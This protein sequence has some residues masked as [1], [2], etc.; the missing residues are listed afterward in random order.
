MV[1]IRRTHDRIPRETGGRIYGGH[2]A[3]ILHA[4]WRR[5]VR[6]KDVAPSAAAPCAAPASRSRQTAR[7][8]GKERRSRETPYRASARI[9]RRTERVGQF[10]SAERARGLADADVARATRTGTKRRHRGG[11]HTV[12][13]GRRLYGQNVPPPA[14]RLARV[15][16]A[17]VDD[18]HAAL[19]DGL[20][21]HGAIG[22]ASQ[23]AVTCVLRVVARGGKRPR[24]DS[25]KG[26]VD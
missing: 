7:P 11:K 12:S 24:H 2:A 21:V 9:R 13:G 14:S 17:S 6:S 16:L 23:A 10:P 1:P 8:K 3:S 26:L 15:V 22:R 4:K 5:A 20:G 18:Q 19:G 25:R